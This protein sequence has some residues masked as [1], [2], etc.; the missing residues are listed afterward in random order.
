MTFLIGCKLP[1]VDNGVWVGDAEPGE[2]M[3]L[4]CK[5]DYYHTVGTNIVRCSSSDV[6]YEGI[7]KCIKESKSGFASV[8][9]SKLC[10]I[11]LKNLIDC[12]H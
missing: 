4:M 1:K 8:I 7:S 9:K 3:K 5:E 6:M 12:F 11:E 2:P 10:V